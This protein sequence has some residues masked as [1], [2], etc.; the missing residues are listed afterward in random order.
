[1]QKFN[2]AFSS[3]LCPKMETMPCNFLSNFLWIC[4]YASI[5]NEVCKYTDYQPLDSISGPEEALGEGTKLVFFL[6]SL[7]QRRRVV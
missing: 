7:S 2:L 5:E 3:C 1:M 4:S 6:C